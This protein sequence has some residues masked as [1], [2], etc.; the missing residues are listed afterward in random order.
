MK[1][2]ERQ[3][4]NALRKL[5]ADRGLVDFSSNDYLGLSASRSLADLTQQIMLEQGVV[6]NGSTGSRLISGNY[7]LYEQTEL[8]L[9]E[10]YKA[11]DALIF[12]SGYDANIGFFSSVPQ[13]GDVVLYDEWIHASVRDG[14]RMSMSRNYRFRHNDLDHLEELLHKHAGAGVCY[15]VTESVF[16]MDGD[17]PAMAELVKLCN[18]FKALLVVDEAHAL[19]VL[20]PQGKGLTYE[21]SIRSG[22]FARILTFGKAPGVHGAAVLGT[23][24]LKQYLLNFARS[25]IYTTALPPHSLASILASHQLMQEEL[26]RKELLDRIAFADVQ[27]REK[28]KGMKCVSG[29]SSITSILLPGNDLVKEIAGKLV[30]A[31]YDVKPILSPTVPKG[32]ERIRICL[33]SFNSFEEIEGLFDRLLIFVKPCLSD[34]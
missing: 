9:K 28:L 34:V 12:N 2:E 16:S 23:S 5:S 25:F 20:G 33:H 3:Q 32:K 22:V 1:L 17:S 4:N 29:N 14:L 19:G 10:C 31:G 27:A 24:G 15:V 13:R 21:E 11:E 6:K 18:S 30:D 7:P 8:F 26:P